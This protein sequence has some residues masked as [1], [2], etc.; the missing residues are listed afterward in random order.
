MTAIPYQLSHLWTLG[1]IDESI[2]AN[3][4]PLHIGS[5]IDD[6][7]EFSAAQVAGL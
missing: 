2:L 7:R 5:L 4:D 1:S 6:G 3:V